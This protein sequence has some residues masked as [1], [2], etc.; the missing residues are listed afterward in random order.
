MAAI[1]VKAYKSIKSE[2]ERLATD[3][4]ALKDELK[5]VNSYNEPYNEPLGSGSSTVDLTAY[6]T[7]ETQEKPDS[8]AIKKEL[9][10]QAMSELGKRSAKKR[11]E[12]L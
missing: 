11:K 5:A 8:D 2:N 7:V 1:G 9:I 6:P 3:K 4:Q 12:R 10:R